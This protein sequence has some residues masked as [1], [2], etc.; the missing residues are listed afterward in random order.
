VIS[1]PS[2]LIIL[3]HENGIETIASEDRIENEIKKW[4]RW[5]IQPEKTGKKGK[6]NKETIP[7]GRIT[8]PT[9]GMKTRFEMS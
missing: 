3:I 5:I 4:Q 9:T 6:P 7:R 1:D 8:N 2:K